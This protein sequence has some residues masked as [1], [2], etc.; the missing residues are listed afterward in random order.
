MTLISIVFT[1]T[2]SSLMRHKN[3][4]ILQTCLID[5]LKSLSNLC[6]YIAQSF[7]IIIIFDNRGNLQ[8]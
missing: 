8:F 3:Y 1:R 7:Q 6:H 5:I 4:F 2:V